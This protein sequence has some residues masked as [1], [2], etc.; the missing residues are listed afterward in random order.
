[1]QVQP[2]LSIYLLTKAGSFKKLQYEP[3]MFKKE[4]KAPK[5]GSISREEA[6]VT[7]VP[8]RSGRVSETPGFGVVKVIQRTVAPKVVEACW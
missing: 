8:L 1:M 7:P 4:V 2:D 5:K 3:E 6:F